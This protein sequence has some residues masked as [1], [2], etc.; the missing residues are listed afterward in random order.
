MPMLLGLDLGTSSV[1]AL[2][3]SEDGD[4]LGEGSASYSVHS[5]RQ[6][7]AESSPEDWWNAAVEAT[8]AAVGSSGAA[9]G[10]GGGG[11][12][13]G[14]ARWGTLAA[15]A[16]PANRRDRRPDRGAEE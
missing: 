13:R 15:G 11:H 2:L 7:W 4:T 16:R 6:G 3:M 5:P 9:G 12:G 10:G 8:Q 1:K 14:D